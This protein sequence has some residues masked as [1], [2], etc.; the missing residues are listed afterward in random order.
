VQL[1]YRTKRK[2][3]LTEEGQVFLEQARLTLTQ[4]DKAVTM[5]R[6]RCCESSMFENWFCAFS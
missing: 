3:E 1:F 2:V 6:R 4:A 5:A